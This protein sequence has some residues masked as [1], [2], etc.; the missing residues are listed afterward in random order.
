MATLD[1]P[2]L[3]KRGL[4]RKRIRRFG[5][6]FTGIKI[7]LKTQS[8][9]RFHFVATIVVVVMGVLLQVSSVEWVMIIMLIGMVF[10]AE[11][12]NTALEWLCDYVQPSYHV[13]IKAVKDLGVTG[14]L[15]ISI[16]ALL[17]GGIIFI[18]KLYTIILR[19]LD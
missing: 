18:P 12:F 9:A 1:R 8:N 4:I 5:F 19:L 3:T 7:L 17:I 6:A 15:M 13:K 16:C 2:N 14:V 11:I 10:T